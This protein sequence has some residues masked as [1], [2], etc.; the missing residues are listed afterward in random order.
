ME[1]VL[2]KDE[3]GEIMISQLKSFRLFLVRFNEAD[4]K[5]D[6][7]YQRGE[8]PTQVQSNRF[9]KLKEEYQ[10]YMNFFSRW[11]VDLWDSAWTPFEVAKRLV[12]ESM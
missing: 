6:E 4:R 8:T 2:Y 11:D 7:M 10:E 9:Q 1:N 3:M 12:S 5:I